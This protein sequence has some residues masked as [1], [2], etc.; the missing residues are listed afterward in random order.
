[1][2]NPVESAP[3]PSLAGCLIIA[4]RKRAGAGFTHYRQ[5]AGLGLQALVAAPLACLWSAGLLS[6]RQLAD[7]SEVAGA[8]EGDLAAAQQ[9]PQRDRQVEAV[10]V[11][12]Q[13][14]GSGSSRRKGADV[15]CML[16][17]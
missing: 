14:G 3:P 1:M 2:E 5:P 17:Y 4:Y 7:E 12:F 10:G 13:I 9:L 15:H 16:Y 8:V 11:L 6:E